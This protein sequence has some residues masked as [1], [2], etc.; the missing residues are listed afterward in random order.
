M[1]KQSKIQKAKYEA[2]EQYRLEAC[3]VNI[4]DKYS[5]S[6]EYKAF[7]DTVRQIRR[8]EEESP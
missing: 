4:Y 2:R 1:T 7:E 5:E 3:T 6:A 8:E